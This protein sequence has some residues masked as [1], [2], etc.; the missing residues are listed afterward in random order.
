MD[1]KKF[2]ISGKKLREH[3]KALRLSQEVIAEKMG[4]TRATANNWEHKVEISMNGEEATRL[5][6]LLKA[7]MDDLTVDHTQPEGKIPEK[8]PLGQYDAGNMYRQFFEDQ[9]DYLVIPRIMFEDYE[10]VPKSEQ[11]AKRKLVEEA[12]ASQKDFIAMLKNNLEDLRRSQD[13]GRSLK[14]QKM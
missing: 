14:S 11:D 13:L 10:I 8:V 4:V 12:L 5:A 2:Y 3:R 7:S 1:E 9:T 6:K